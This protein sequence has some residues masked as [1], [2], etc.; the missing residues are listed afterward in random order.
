MLHKANKTNEK[1]DNNF[2]D[3]DFY[4]HNAE[5]HGKDALSNIL[6]ILKKC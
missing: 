5:R 4:V 6:F 2:Y 1:I 3:F